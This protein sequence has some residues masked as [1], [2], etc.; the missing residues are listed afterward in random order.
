LFKKE[1]KQPRQEQKVLPPALEVGGSASS[2]IRK[3]VW[4]GTIDIWKNYSIFGTGVETFAYS[5]Y[6]FR[7][8]EHNMVSEWDY[9]YN[10]AHNEYLN[11]AATTGTYGLVTYL[12][13]IFSILF[14]LLSKSNALKALG[15]KKESFFK[16]KTFEY[17]VPDNRNDQLLN[18]AF[19]SGFSSILVT[20]FFG[21][22]VVPVAIIFFIY[23]AMSLTLK[24]EDHKEKDINPTGAQYL[25][26]ALSLLV[27]IISLIYW[28]RYWYADYL[29]AHGE[30]ENEAQNLQRARSLLTKAVDLNPNE[31]IYWI[32]LSEATAK[33]A[34]ALQEQENAQLATQAARLAANEAETAA[35]L[36]PADVN[37]KRRQAGVYVDISQIDINYLINARDV[38]LNAIK[39]APTDPKLFYNLGLAYLRTG[40]QEEALKI[41]EETVEL[42]PDYRNAR[43]AVAL[44]SIDLKDYEKAQDELEY[45]LENINPNDAVARRELEEL[46]TR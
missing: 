29:Y 6:N 27:T 16:G 42:K 32:E 14:Y 17:K 2:R 39:L 10:K 34:V 38:L 46:P 5:Y 23:P 15:I 7:P 24:K 30:A 20:N 40:N 4:Q 26:I 28:G 11:F 36:S 45:I 9:L 18:L 1:Q 13:L 44:V 19:L 35:G 43:F 21:F 22:S 3:I 12:F 33:T 8:Q 37:V 31:A 41:F 25:I